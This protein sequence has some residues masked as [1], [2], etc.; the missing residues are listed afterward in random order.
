MKG[1][2]VDASLTVYEPAVKVKIQQILEGWK[3]MLEA[4][5]LH[6]TANLERNWNLVKEQDRVRNDFQKVVLPVAAVRE[7]EDR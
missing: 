3:A 1:D 2:K 5:E 6:I 7:V 4:P